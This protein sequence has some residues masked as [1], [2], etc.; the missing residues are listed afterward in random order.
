MKEG[1]MIDHDRLFK[2]L[3][4]TFFVEFIEL[5]LPNVAGYLDRNRIEFLDKELFTDVTAGDRHEADLVVKARFRDQET[6]FLVHLETQ[7]TPEPSFAKRMFRYF[8]RLH[9]KHDLPVY[10][11]A[12]FTYDAPQRPEPDRYSVSFPDKTIIAFEFTVIQL[13][14]MNWRDFVRQANPVAS[15]LMAKMKIATADRPRVKLECLRLLATLH[16][17]LAKMQLISGFVDTYLRLNQEEQQ[18][19][20]QEVGVLNLSEKES[21]MQLTT[22]WKEEGIVEGVH[23]GQTGLLLRQLRR[24][25][26]ELPQ[27]LVQKID[28]LSDNRLGEMAEALLDFTSLADASA[29]LD[30]AAK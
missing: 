19:F 11:I 27:A 3:L 20:R 7:S 6:C 5:F 4:T 28:A 13:N 10:P 26:G 12:L 14:R 2:E 1:N 23:R 8:A 17:D 25:F 16:L 18:A 15:A 21:V 9:E 24:R 22:S 29:W 30:A